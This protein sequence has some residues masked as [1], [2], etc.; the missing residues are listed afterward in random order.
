ME[1]QRV[2]VNHGWLWIMHAYRL[3]M[4]SPLQALSMAMAF[5][6]LMF[7]IMLVPVVG[8]LLAILTM[9]VL[10]AGYARTCKALEFSAKVEPRFAFAG[11]ENKT[12]KL[13]NLGVMLLLGIMLVS[14][15]TS[16]LGGG[17]LN[18]ILKAYQVHHDPNALLEAMLAPESGVRA[19]LFAGFA[20]LFTLLLAMQFAPM[21]VFFNELTPLEAL[22]QSLFASVRNIIPFS[23]YSLIMQVFAF[24]LSAIPYGL[25]WIILLPIGLTSMYVAYRDIFS[26]P[27]KAEV[28]RVE[29]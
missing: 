20:L 12:A 9:P 26:E 2:S 14:I 11:F 19:A 25:G 4:R 29:T 17:A 21:L 24:V 22:K 27:E 28:Q 8:P 3:L 6:M 1:I 13:A 18:E 10:M 15:V 23:V 7:L 5:A 16:A